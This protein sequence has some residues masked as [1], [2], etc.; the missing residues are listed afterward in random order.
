M[1]Y[2]LLSKGVSA[3][4]IQ[5]VV[6]IVLKHT[7]EFDLDKIHLT[8]RTT[9]QRMVSEAGEL[10]NIRATYEIA[11]EINKLCQMSDRT[12]K[13]LI[14][15]GSHVIKLKPPG[16]QGI[17]TFSLTVSPMIS[18]K[19]DDTL[20]QLQ[21]QFD[22]MS[23][24]ADDLDRN[25]SKDAFSVTRIN[26]RMSD[27]AANEKKV[28]KLIKEKR[29]TIFDEKVKSGLMSEAENKNRVTFFL[30]RVLPIKSTTWQ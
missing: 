19:A 27:R 1:Y 18:R 13:H 7:T 8:S 24:L 30:L 6:K 26:C 10:A 20:K 29:D 23:S 28:T 25:C 4:T 12:T 15:W 2:D 21:E 5:S 11:K 14:H 17:K 16:D 9:A 3:N 22:N